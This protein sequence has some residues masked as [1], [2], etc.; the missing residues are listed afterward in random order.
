MKII[1]V[2]D[3]EYEKILDSLIRRGDE[4]FLDVDKQV[5]EIIEKCQITK[6]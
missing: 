1:E 4:D 2:F 6:R 5:T 3:T